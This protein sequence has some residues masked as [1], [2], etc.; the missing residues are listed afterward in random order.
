MF[1]LSAT[2]RAIRFSN[3]LSAKKYWMSG[4][5]ENITD[6]VAYYWYVLLNVCPKFLKEHQMLITSLIFSVLS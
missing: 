4:S 3:G 1:E 5:L 2:R 6:N